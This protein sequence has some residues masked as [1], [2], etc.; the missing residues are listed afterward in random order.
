MSKKP[1]KVFQAPF[2]IFDM[3][4]GD[5]GMEIFCKDREFLVKRAF[6]GGRGFRLKTFRLLGC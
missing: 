5:H 1:P 6:L 2:E 3:F 4:V